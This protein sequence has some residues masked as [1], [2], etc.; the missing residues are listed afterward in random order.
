MKKGFDNKVIDL[1]TTVVTQCY[2]LE[3]FDV[4]TE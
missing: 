2:S 4:S 1:A 3:T